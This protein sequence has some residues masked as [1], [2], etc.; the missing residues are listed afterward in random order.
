MY[1]PDMSYPLPPP[2]QYPPPPGYPHASAGYGYT[3]PMVPT[4]RP[5][6]VTWF[7][8]YAILMALLYLLF[9]GFGVTV[10]VVGPEQFAD[11][12]TSA[13]EWSVIAAIIL[14]VGLIFC[15]PYAIAP[16]LPRK[17]GVW[18]YD[19]VLI[20]LGLGSACLWPLTIPLLIFWIKPENKLW[21]G[22]NV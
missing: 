19:L 16:F 6:V 3:P 11:A 10:M 14:V 4:E 17:P 13:Q 15:L 7:T 2:P 1:H 22:R 8:V 18:I 12:E 21:F 5:G 20:A 9:A